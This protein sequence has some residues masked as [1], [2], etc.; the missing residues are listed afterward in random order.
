MLSAGYETPFRIRLL[1]EPGTRDGAGS[2]HHDGYQTADTP[3]RGTDTPAAGGYT[4]TTPAG[5]SVGIGIIKGSNLTTH[6]QAA[7][8]TGADDTNLDE[9]AFRNATSLDVF[10]T[11]ATGPDLAQRCAIASASRQRGRP[12]CVA[13]PPPAQL[14]CSRPVQQRS[15]G[16]WLRRTR[17][18]RSH[19]HLPGRGARHGGGG[20]PRG[21]P[22]NR[23]SRS[24]HS[25]VPRT[26][27]TPLR[28][29]PSG[30]AAARGGGGFPPGRPLSA[31]RAPTPCR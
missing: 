26:N 10:A 24:G 12:G 5:G 25:Q 7:E 9:G 20:R 23:R 1:W 19:R 16:A 8:A 27:A 31:R 13:L 11:R 4:T 30:T 2:D 17:G 29:R 21:D 22:A 18:V 3:G 15:A 6:T 28:R 14:P